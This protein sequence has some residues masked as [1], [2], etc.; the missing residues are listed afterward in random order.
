M[1]FAASPCLLQRKAQTNEGCLAP[2]AAISPRLTRRKHQSCGGLVYGI[3]PIG[4]GLTLLTIPDVAA[5]LG[6]L[7][8]H[9]DV[10]LYPS[11]MTLRV[12]SVYFIVCARSE[13]T[14]YFRAS[15]PLGHLAP[16]FFATFAALNVTTSALARRKPSGCTPCG[17]TCE[18]LSHT[19]YRSLVSVQAWSHRTPAP[20]RTGP[21]SPCVQAGDAWPI[22][23]DTP[24]PSHD[25]RAPGSVGS[26]P[27]APWR[28]PR[29]RAAPGFSR[30][31]AHQS[32]TVCGFRGQWF[33][34]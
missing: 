29:P 18:R 10:W 4:L 17:G 24:P 5:N 11:A 32:T 6:G 23:S 27:Q 12:Q 33:P 7:E 15:A 30:E 13:S 1:G 20:Y 31:R 34:R 25:R 22:H 28:L 26:H 3:N 21:E 8:L 9:K 19:P 16:V 14:K 2:A